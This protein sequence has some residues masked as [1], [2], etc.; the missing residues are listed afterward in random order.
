MNDI[1]RELLLTGHVIIYMDDILIFT[2]DLTTHQLI[3]WK[4]LSLLKNNNLFL[5]LE[6]CTFEALEVEYLGV[7]V[8]QGKIRMDP[9][10]IQAI[11]LWPTL[12]SKKDVQQLLGF[13]NY[14]RCFVCDFAKTVQPLYHLCGSN[15]WS[16][17]T[18]K[19]DAFTSLRHAVATG[20]TLAIPLDDGPFLIEANSSG[21][22][23]GAVNSKT[24]LG[25]LLL[26]YPSPSVMSSTTSE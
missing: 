24:S 23:M 8:S 16:W 19:H 17:S 9:K 25:N 15:P 5:K 20:P 2:N 7:I 12:I 11:Q 6:K 1:F 22:A 21:Y 13:V 3:T 14:Y 10:K 18:S 4:V 26:S